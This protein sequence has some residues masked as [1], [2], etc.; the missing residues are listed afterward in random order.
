M[1]FFFSPPPFL[2]FLFS[3]QASFA[4][5]PLAV[6]SGLLKAPGH[7][8]KS[9]HRACL[10]ALRSRSYWSKRGM[11]GGPS[12]QALGGAST[13]GPVRAVPGHGGSPARHR[14]PQDH[15]RLP[16][17]KSLPTSKHGGTQASGRDAGDEK[18]R[19]WLEA[20]CVII[21]LSPSP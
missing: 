11:R 4:A 21:P 9:D 1:T 3:F 20:T 14:F 5:I 18:C 19:H 2:S 8:R 13:R 15:G 17:L 7:E 10:V 6:G 16:D 12:R